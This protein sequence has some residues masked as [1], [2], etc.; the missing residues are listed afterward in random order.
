MEVL[1]KVTAEDR[2]EKKNRRYP[3]LSIRF[4]G[5]KFAPPPPAGF[6]NTAQK[7]LDQRKLK[8]CDF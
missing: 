2:D 4:R 3:V 6:L 7:L 1:I 8:L 5:D